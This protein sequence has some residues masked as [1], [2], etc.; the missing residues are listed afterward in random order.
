MIIIMAKRQAACNLDEILFFYVESRYDWTV[1]GA[2][3]TLCH[4]VSQEVATAV[5]E[6]SILHKTIPQPGNSSASHSCTNGTNYSR[7][8]QMHTVRFMTTSVIRNISARSRRRTSTSNGSKDLSRMTSFSSNSPSVI[9]MT[10]RNNEWPRSNTSYTNTHTIIIN[11]MINTITFYFKIG[12]ECMFSGTGSPGSSWING[13]LLF[14]H[15]YCYYKRK[16]ESVSL[17][18]KSHWFETANVKILRTGTSYH[19]YISQRLVI[20]VKARFCV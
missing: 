13:S 9:T 6:L 7:E 11:I 8:S 4:T 18:C 15:Y 3:C 16:L 5:R 19:I 10:Y 1:S 17:R 2:A 12:S 14:L 20:N